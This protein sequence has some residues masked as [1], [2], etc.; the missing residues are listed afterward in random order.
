LL[1]SL[2]ACDV[3]ITPKT[4]QFAKELLGKIPRQQQQPSRAQ[5]EEQQKIDYLKK[6][7]SYKLVLDQDTDTES[8]PKI[9][10]EPRDK[11]KKRKHI[12][13]TKASTIED[14]EEPEEIPEKKPKLTEE[15]TEEE[16]AERMERDAKEVK[17]WSEKFKE[18]DSKKKQE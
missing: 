18:K 17:E 5:L 9:R 4:E 11:E 3:P 13:T 16:K 1:E 15:E 14:E 8:L 10:K 6:N 7:E 12:R 2:K